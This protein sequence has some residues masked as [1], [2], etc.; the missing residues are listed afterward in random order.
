MMRR[1]AGP[2]VTG[3]VF[4][5]PVFLTVIL[6]QWVAGYVTAALG[7]GTVI[8]GVL[9]SGG[10]LVTKSRF[11]AF[12]AGLGIAAL[13]VWGIGLLVQTQWRARLEGGLDGLLGRVPVLG[14][15]YRPLAQ[16]I[17]MIGGAPGGELQGMRVVAVRFGTD[18]EVLGLLATPQV[19]DLG[20]GPRHLVVCPTAPVPVGGAMIFVE[21]SRVRAVPGIGVDDLA[22]FYV[23]MGTVAPAGLVAA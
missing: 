10:M 15:F 7:P 6:L 20:E 18:T 23:S 1:I 5:A 21:V 8:G 19:F 14:G 11:L 17:R 13:I 9:A 3:M 12:W 16:I 4:L 2:F 22:K